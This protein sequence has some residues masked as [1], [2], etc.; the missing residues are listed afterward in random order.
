MVGAFSQGFFTKAAVFSR[1][2]MTRGGIIMPGTAIPILDGMTCMTAEIA[3]FVE[4]PASL[5][6]AVSMVIPFTI[7]CCLC[8]KDKNRDER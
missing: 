4:R 5:P 2:F 3:A 8:G 1:E 6:S 7:S